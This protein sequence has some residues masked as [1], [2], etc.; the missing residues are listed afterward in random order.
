MADGIGPG[1]WASRASASSIFKGEWERPMTRC[2]SLIVSGAV[3]GLVSSC[4]SGGFRHN[5][6]RRE[7][8]DK[9]GI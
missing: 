2:K 7:I 8:A 5:P 3:I 4:P 9:E 1:S 6:E